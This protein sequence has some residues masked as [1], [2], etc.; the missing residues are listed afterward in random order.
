MWPFNK[1]EKCAG[2]YVRCAELYREYYDEGGEMSLQQ[3]TAET[4]KR[5]KVDHAGVIKDHRIK[6]SERRTA[7]SWGEMTR[8][9]PDTPPYYLIGKRTRGC[10]GGDVTPEV[11]A[12]DI[13][14]ARKLAE[15]SPR[16]RAIL[17][18]LEGTQ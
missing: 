8:L 1:L 11:L 4:R 16:L 6:G 15:H 14:T 13:N 18:E 3:F 9:R 17:N 10:L 12:I 2:Q 7:Y 5:Y